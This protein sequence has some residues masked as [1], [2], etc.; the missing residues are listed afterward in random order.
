MSERV[1]D[2]FARRWKNKASD[3]WVF[4]N[5]RGTSHR[6]APGD[7][8]GRA[9]R[10]AK[11]EDLRIHDLRHTAAARLIRNGCTL[12]EVAVILGH[13]DLK[14]TARYAFLAEEEVSKKA[15]DIFNKL[16][17]QRM[18]SALRVV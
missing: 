15:R 6:S 7:A 16:N 17:V 2:V 18:K 12:H 14:T 3:E 11:I 1:Q 4:P 13:S 5:K 8:F 10:K 9:R